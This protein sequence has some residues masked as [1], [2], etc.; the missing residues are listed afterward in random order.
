MMLT[1]N[2][3]QY[4]ER[5]YEW[6]NGFTDGIMGNGSD[7]EYVQEMNNKQDVEEYLAGFLVGLDAYDIMNNS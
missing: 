2:S 4:T 1:K 3:I 6:N 5:S 7:D